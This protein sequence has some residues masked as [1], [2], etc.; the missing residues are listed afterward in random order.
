MYCDVI[1]L[2][3]RC[4]A[5]ALSPTVP[6][7]IFEYL[8]LYI[9][10]LVLLLLLLCICYYN[11]LILSWYSIDFYLTIFI[12]LFLYFSIFYKQRTMIEPIFFTTIQDDIIWVCCTSTAKRL[13]QNQVR[14]TP[15]GNSYKASYCLSFKLFIFYFAPKKSTPFIYFPSWSSQS[16]LFFFIFVVVKNIW[17]LFT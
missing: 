2:P 11:L 13:E 14:H 8:I 1:E 10:C 5:W 6:Q 9:W 3:L 4:Y 16:T 15:P 12:L 7:N 17:F